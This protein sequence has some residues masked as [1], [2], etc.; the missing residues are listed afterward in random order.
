MALN[1][2]YHLKV[3]KRE[4]PKVTVFCR[5]YAYRL[6]Y[7]PPDASHL[8]PLAIPPPT[9][10]GSPS[11]ENDVIVQAKEEFEAAVVTS[12]V[13]LLCVI[14]LPACHVGLENDLVSRRRA[15]LVTVAVAGAVLFLHPL[16]RPLIGFWNDDEN[17]KAR[18]D[19]H[20]GKDHP[21]KQR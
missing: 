12:A 10:P 18:Y 19:E 17:Y 7:N 3:E 6:H 9:P 14:I 21:L 20:L 11:V 5:N 8:N 13:L 2:F 1:Y 15:M 4:G 16:L